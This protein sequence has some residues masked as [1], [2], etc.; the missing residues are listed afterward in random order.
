M[1]YAF[2]TVNG[3]RACPFCRE[4]F[5]KDETPT[6]PVCG[7]NL[8]PLAQLPN[9]TTADDGETDPRYAPLPWSYW[10]RARGLLLALC[11]L[12]LVMFAVPWVHMA[13]PAKYV[14]RG[15]EI[16]KRTG[17]TWAA[18][19][20]WFTLFPLVLSR[21]SIMQM[22]GARAIATVLSMIPALIAGIFLLF[23]P[24]AIQARGITIH[25]RFHWDMGIYATLILGLISAY[26][27]AFH[28]G[29]RLDDT[30]T[31]GS[32]VRPAPH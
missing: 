8:L 1:S 4:L 20:A 26:V 27:S 10:G 9:N 23:P 32:A 13:F 3:L 21:R 14:L 6:C 19:V 7:L 12:G 29:G 28:F 17:L 22:R 30:T 16:A 31:K 2:S 24:H 15:Y 18:G 5:P 25:M 11:I